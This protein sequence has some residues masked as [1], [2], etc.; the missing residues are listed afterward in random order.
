ML[1]V[2][3]TAPEFDRPLLFLAARSDTGGSEAPDDKHGTGKGEPIYIASYRATQIA[4]G[5]DISKHRLDIH[6][7]PDGSIGQFSN[8]QVG[9][10][11]ADCLDYRRNIQS[12][13]HLRGHRRLLSG[14]CKTRSPTPSLPW[15]QDQSMAG[16]SLRRGDRAA[17]QDR[18]GRC[19]DAGALRGDPATRHGARPGRRRRQ[20]WPN[21]WPPAGLW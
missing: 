8:D 12:P 16:A 1:Q 18:S 21:C 20:P 7:H 5:I 6:V 11:Q 14:H 15:R 9:S 10:Y 17:G 13:D 19:R 4:I 3:R 2:E